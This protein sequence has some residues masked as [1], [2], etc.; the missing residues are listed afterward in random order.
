MAAN[1]NSITISSVVR[2]MD[3]AKEANQVA[4]S[5]ATVRNKLISEKSVN[6]EKIIV[7]ANSV[8]KNS[9]VSVVFSVM[10]IEAFINEYGI[11]QF[12]K[13]FFKTHLD[14][15]SLISK[16]ILIPRLANKR[17]LDTDGQIYED[18]KW[19]IDLRNSLVHFRI[20]K[21]DVEDIDYS[22][23]GSQNDFMLEQ[24][25]EKAVHAM[26]ALIAYFNSER[27]DT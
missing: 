27:V 2:Y 26:E 13:K 17:Q 14:N 9:T 3:I 8:H 10:A 12:S 6:H 11:T 21:R 16:L 1:E 7:T 23:P 22:D 25:S 4:Q 20:S 19:L 5:S 15:L 24:H 18:A